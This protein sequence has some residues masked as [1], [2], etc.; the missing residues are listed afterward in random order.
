M[1]NMII[2]NKNLTKNSKK[3]INLSMQNKLLLKK[4]QS[5]KK[6]LHSKIQKINSLKF[7]M[8]SLNQK[9]KLTQ[10]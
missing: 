4:Y 9:I 10:N 6:Y 2:K 7:L 8:K 1:T 3:L 5:P